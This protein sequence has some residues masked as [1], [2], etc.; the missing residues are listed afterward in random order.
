MINKP[1]L[2]G[3]LSYGRETLTGVSYPCNGNWVVLNFT[4]KYVSVGFTT[5]AW[6]AVGMLVSTQNAKR[7]SRDGQHTH[8]AFQGLLAQ[9]FLGFGKVYLYVYPRGDGMR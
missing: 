9:V 6:G 4:H 7:T 3:C 1:F 5:S 2:G 8:Q